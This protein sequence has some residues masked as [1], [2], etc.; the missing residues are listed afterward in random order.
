M[1]IKQKI[2]FLLLVSFSC[3]TSLEAKIKLPALVGNQ[4]VLQQKTEV[5][6][7]GWAN[8]GENIKIETQWLDQPTSTVAGKDSLWKVQVKTPNAGGPYAITLT[9][10]NTIKLTD[11]LIGEVWVCSGQSNMEKPIGIQPGQKP[12]FNFE[13]EIKAANYPNIR[14]FHVP[15]KKIATVQSDVESTWEICTPQSVDSLKF[16]AVAYFFGRELYK[17]LN[18]PIGLIDASWGGTRIEPWIP[19]EGFKNIQGLDSLYQLAKRVDDTMNKHNPTLLY[20]GM[21]APLTNYAVKGVIWY[22]GESNLMDLNDGLLYEQKMKAMIY[23]WRDAWKND[24]LPI[25]YVQ[26]SP[27]RYYID[28]TDRVDSPNELPLIWEAQT[29][30]L[31]ISNT[32]M[33]VTTDLV[34]DLS[35]IHPRNKQDV[36]K[37]LAL[38][39]LAKSYDEN[40]LT[41]SGPKYKSMK[42]KNGKV[43]LSFDF[44]DGGLKSGDDKPLN[45]FTI[46][47]ADNTFVPAK[48]EIKGDKVIVYSQNIKKPEAVRFAWDEEAQ[49]N[50]FNAADLP[51][52]P[53]RTDNWKMNSK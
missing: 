44:V 4:M 30:C 8:P 39:A 36:G 43:I 18:V 33:I 46:A 38:V 19:T 41:Y 26:I 29:N 40:K 15:R 13:E 35:D 16:S 3:Y 51:A 49:P 23:S 5:N 28:R 45:W 2:T 52:I 50:F 12:V 27:Y 1:N 22:Q 20:N 17:Q 9:G 6:I 14:L 25:Y 31:N 32:G 11:I 34:D 24:K 42:I 37:R 21:I 47:G 53:F 10:E 7:W 48:A